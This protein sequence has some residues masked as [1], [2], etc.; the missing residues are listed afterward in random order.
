[1]DSQKP[2]SSRFW[3]IYKLGGMA[4]A[5]ASAL[6]DPKAQQMA[7]IR[8]VMKQQ[9]K[10]EI[11]DTPLKEIE[12]TVFD[13]ETTG[14]FINQGDEIISFGAVHVNGD[15]ILEE[16]TFHQIVNPQR[17]I[18]AHIEELT[19]ITNEIAKSSA[20]LI[21]GLQ[22]FFQFVQKR[23]L[24]AHG[25]GHD[26]QFLN[27]ALWKTSKTSLTHRVLD[28]MM[29]AKW[30]EPGRTDFELDRL[31]EKYDIPIANRHHALEDSIMTAKL[32]CAF[33]RMM[34]ER[35]VLTMGDLYAHLSR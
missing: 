33:V 30:L 17:E 4:P 15:T 16:E 31:L 12:F 21:D 13:L 10:T 1:M 7:F 35:K 19:G 29:I 20:G 11:F 27:N 8:S 26:K 28:T 9:R 6:G 5:F 18:P 24:I 22:R 3:N 34:E 32:W 14:F 2:G 25:T 23:V